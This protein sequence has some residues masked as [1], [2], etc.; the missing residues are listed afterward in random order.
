MCLKYVKI[1][2]EKE[3]SDINDKESGIWKPCVRMYGIIRPEMPRF[4]GRGSQV[5][6]NGGASSGRKFLA[7]E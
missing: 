1:I 6:S 3:K 5:S 4:Y 7:Q 2:K